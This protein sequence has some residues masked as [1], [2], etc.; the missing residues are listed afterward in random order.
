M[1]TSRILLFIAFLCSFQLASAQFQEPEDLLDYYFITEH[2]QVL[3]L[4]DTQL[5]DIKNVDDI[6]M[7]T[8]ETQLNGNSEE[9]EK[10]MDQRLKLLKG[11]L[12][13][14]QYEQLIVIAEGKLEED[15]LTAYESY[16]SQ[17]NSENPG[18]NM[19]FEQIEHYFMLLDSLNKRQLVLE[20]Y[21]WNDSKKAELMKMERVLQA[22]QFAI[23]K[24][25]QRLEE[26]VVANQLEDK[27]RAELPII[28]AFVQLYMDQFV[29]K[30][31]I[32]RTRFEKELSPSD[33]RKIKHYRLLLDEVIENMKEEELQ[34]SAK[35]YQN[36][37]I[38]DQALKNEMEELTLYA[39]DGLKKVPIMM[40]ALYGSFIDQ[41]VVEAM[42]EMTEKYMPVMKK[43][44]VAFKVLFKELEKG[45]KKIAEDYG[46]NPAFKETMVKA[47]EYKFNKTQGLKFLLTTPAE[48]EE[49]ELNSKDVH[50]AKAFP[51]PAKTIQTLEFNLRQA[52]PVQI[53]II[54][55]KG[56]IVQ[57][58]FSGTLGIG[59]H[60]LNVDVQRLNGTIFFYR[61]TSS[62]GTSTLDIMIAK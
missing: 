2:A 4:S 24:E 53:E 59:V 27:L 23:F 48:I 12:N 47:P 25:N 7:E 45:H 8:W 38:K 22:E 19:T 50:L 41:E 3:N 20:G 55:Q 58:V 29:P 31:Q 46:N 9:L 28:K 11:I 16:L 36:F 61:I 18:L 52:S 37:L 33:Q 49:E 57:N 62:T 5:R 35:S 51:S 34:N 13:D 40:D 17:I 44:E 56:Q 30:L 1:K 43:Q 21:N 6:L 54:D 10:Y 42:I 32:L 39:F 60:Q 14:E 26:L 15:K